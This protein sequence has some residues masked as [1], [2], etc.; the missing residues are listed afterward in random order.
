MR[1]SI[2]TLAALCAAVAACSDVAGPDQKVNRELSG[3]T[4]ASVTI[5]PKVDT[6]QVGKSITLTAV[7]KTAGGTEIT[8]ATF[9]WGITDTNTAKVKAGVVT[10]RKAG[11]VQIVAISGRVY[12]KSTV[13]ITAASSSNDSAAVSESTTPVTSGSLFSGY[14]PT[15]SHYQHIRTMMTDFYYAWTSAERDWAGKHYDAAMSGARDAWKA[16]DPSGVQIPYSLEWSTVVPGQQGDNLLNVYYSDMKSWYASHTQYR[17]E[18]AFLHV[19]GAA[20]RDSASRVVVKIWDTNRWLMNPADPGNRAYQVDRYRRGTANTE[21]AFIDEAGSGGIT[22]F[23]KNVAEFPNPVDYQAPFTSLL[24]EIRQG[25]GNK[26]L[27]LNA[28]EYHAD[29]DLANIRAAGAVQLENFNNP[30]YSGMPSR[31]GWVDQLLADGVTVDLVPVYS[32]EWV[33]R[34]SSLYPAGGIYATSAQRLKM[35]EL[36]SYYMSVGATPDRFYLTLENTWDAPYSSLWLKAQEA[37]IGHPRA[38]RSVFATGTDPVGKSYTVY[39]RDFDRALVLVRGQTGWS[40]QS[41]GSETAARVTL[42][43]GEQWLPLHADGTLGAPVTSVSL[44]N[45]EAMILIK[46]STITN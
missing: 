25:I 44:R 3:S 15:S 2:L 17:L 13:V 21:G 18:D 27:M 32:S 10:G 22:P 5:S 35:W 11:T 43:S 41:Y 6:V 26:I 40:T 20:R 39:G 38:P 23:I 16:V 30:M 37:N 29:W 7:A 45:S 36:S 31:W 34:H 14:S 28:S 19:A 9:Y 33:T 4:A 1:S 12:G 8:G 42:P 46:K 24:A